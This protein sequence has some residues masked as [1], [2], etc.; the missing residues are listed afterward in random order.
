MSAGLDSISSL[1]IKKMLNKV[2][3]WIYVKGMGVDLELV[4]YRIL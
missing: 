1:M 4:I 3:F 2:V